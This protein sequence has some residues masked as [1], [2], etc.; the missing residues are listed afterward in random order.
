MGVP[1]SVIVHTRNEAEN[2]RECLETCSGWAQEI[3]VADMESGDQTLELAEPLCTRI[4]RLPFEPEFD[5]ARNDSAKAASHK[6]ILYLD[7]DERLTPIVRRTIE[8]LL[9]TAEPEVSAFQLPFRVVSFGRWIRHAGNWW[10]SYKSPP[11]LK[12]G[13]FHFPG[14]VHVPAQVDGRVVRV[15]PKSPDDAIIHF[16]HPSVEAYFDKLNRYTGM[17][18]GK[19]RASGQKPDWQAVAD[20]MGA[21]MRWYYDD[22]QGKKDGLAGFLLSLGSGIYEAVAQAKYLEE[23]AV[24][25][26]PPSAEAFFER[27]RTAAAAPTPARKQSFPDWVPRLVSL[28]APSRQDAH[29]YVEGELEWVPTGVSLSTDLPS[30][31][32]H[33][34]AAAVIDATSIH[35]AVFA[36]RLQSRLLPGA[37]VLIVDTSETRKRGL[38]TQIKKHLR[39]VAHSL[40]DAGDSNSYLFLWNDRLDRF[41]MQVQVVGH[42]NALRV[43]GGGE[44]QL[45]ETVHSLRNLKVLCDVSIG[46]PSPGEYDLLHYFSLHHSDSSVPAEVGQI[47]YALTPIFWDRAEL[48]WVGPRLSSLIQRAE[49][50]QEVSAGYAAVRQEYGALN[51]EGR[52]TSKLSDQA[53]ALVGNAFVVLANCKAELDSLNAGLTT[54]LSRHAVIPNAA[55]LDRFSGASSALFANRYGLTDFVLCVGRLEMNKNQATLLFA[56]RDL[57]APVVLIGPEPDPAYSELCRRVAGENSHFLGPLPQPEVASAYTAAAVHCL[58][59]FGE[60]PGLANLEAAAAGCPLVVSKRGA[61]R[62]YFGG[63]AEYC[64][65]LDPESIREAVTKALRPR[66]R[67]RAVELRKKVLSSYTWE[68]AARLTKQE[69]IRVMEK[70]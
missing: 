44:V 19:L 59:S 36:D 22:T 18:V 31:P 40:R 35:D 13:R 1:I 47:P 46:Q 28:L 23:E 43:F 60:T 8:D 11:L 52:L 41:D 70:S 30:C 27:A 53:R 37:F 57:A 61:E 66:A 29:W 56:L 50:E 34:I 14:P 25:S 10:P 33:C 26:I 3:I 32:D 42:A 38:L 20:R 64:D 39:T 49:T 4:L 69:Y 67:T 65:P 62:E 12:K 7:A 24:S 5:R 51:S 15:E 6:W 55:G 21:I 63:Q 54:G 17:E 16:S 48:A 9:E 2:I 58:P 68:R 45:F